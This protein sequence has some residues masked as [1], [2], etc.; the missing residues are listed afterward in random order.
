MVG[1]INK[2]NIHPGADF[3]NK[4]YRSVAILRWKNLWLDVPS[5]MSTFYQSEGIFQRSYT[6]QKF[7]H[8]VCCRIQSSVTEKISELVDRQSEKKETN[9]P[10]F[11]YQMQKWL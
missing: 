8:D 5:H 7:V 2:N 1:G 3:T 4:F 9:E 10:D 6:T 11:Y